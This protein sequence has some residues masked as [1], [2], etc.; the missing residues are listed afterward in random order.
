MIFVLY[1][2]NS[3]SCKRVISFFRTHQIPF[4]RILLGKDPVPI[5]LIKDILELT[6]G[7][8]EE[9]FSFKTQAFLRLNISKNKL[10]EMHT[11]EVLELLSR[12][13]EL[14]KRPIVFQYDK[15]NKPLRLMVGYDNEEIEIFL[16]DE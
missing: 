10:F 11:N 1:S 16:R 3:R 2:L 15:F 7:G 4:N 5:Q 9:I 6:F 12:D 8:Y 13:S 14:L